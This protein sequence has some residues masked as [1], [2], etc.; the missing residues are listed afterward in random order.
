MRIILIISC[1][2]VFHCCQLACYVIQGGALQMNLRRAAMK[3]FSKVREAYVCTECGADYHQWIG[4]C[5]A[6]QEWNS[7]KAIKIAAASEKTM[8]RSSRKSISEQ[9]Q[10]LSALIPMD[11]VSISTLN[12]RQILFSDEVNRILGGGLVRGSVT[13]LA[14]EP[15][16]GKSTLLMQ[17]GAGVASALPQSTTT[18]TTTIEVISSSSDG[19]QNHVDNGPIVYISGEETAQQLVERSRR[20][21]LDVKNIRLLCDTNIDRAGLECIEFLNNNCIFYL[22]LTVVTSSF[23]HMFNH[24]WQYFTNR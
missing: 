16:I 6:C 9:L 13:L 14:G 2:L 15:G 19:N 3:L 23:V 11:S 20:L 8:G 18:A 21:G 7:V 22:F 12:A 24:L 5:S 17:I 1:V 4:R 10:E